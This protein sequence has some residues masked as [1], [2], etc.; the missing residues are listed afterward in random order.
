MKIFNNPKSSYFYILKRNAMKKILATLFLAVLMYPVVATSVVTVSGTLTDMQSGNPIP[1]HLVTIQ[2]DSSQGFIYYKNVY[3]DNNGVYMDTIFS[4][5]N[6]GTIFVQTWDC[7]NDLHQAS[8]SYGPGNY[9][10]VQDFSICNTPPPC[11]ASFSYYSTGNLGMQFIDQSTGYPATWLWDFGDGTTSD[12]QSP[13]HIFPSAGWYTVQ[14]TIADSSAG[15]T[16]TYSEP[17]YVS[18]STGTGCVAAFTYGTNPADSLTISFTDLSEGNPVSWTWS[19][20]DGTYSA[21]QNPVHTYAQ[22]GLYQVCLTIQGTD[23]LCFDTSCDSIWVG[24]NTLQCEAMF[25]YYADSNGTGYGI[26]FIDLSIGDITGWLWEF[27]DG[28]GSTEQNPYHVYAD[29]GTYTVCLTIAGPDSSC[30]DTYCM[31]VRIGNGTDCSSYF[32]Y[33]AVNLTV[34]FAGYMNNSQQATYNWQFGD[35]STGQGQSVTHTYGQPGSY[36]VELTTEDSTGCLYSSWQTLIVGD[37][38]LY[39]QVYGQ[40]FEGSFPMGY[41]MVMIF[42]A[43]SMLNYLPYM[44]YSLV[45]SSGIYYFAYVPAG[46]YYIWAI[47]YGTGYLPT[48][49][50]DVLFWEDATVVTLGEPQNSYD[51]HLIP[52]PGYSTGPGDIEGHIGSGQIKSGYMDKISMLIENESGQVL[53]HAPVN[54]EGNFDFTGLSHG[55]YFLLAELP[56]CPSDLVR[57]DITPENEHAVVNLTFSNGKILGVDEPVSLAGSVVLYPNPARDQVTVALTL[58]QPVTA[59]V[60]LVGMTGQVVYHERVALVRGG[61]RIVLSLAPVAPG[62]YTVRIV[63]GEGVHILQKLLKTP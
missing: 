35:G 33:S 46:S 40:V 55:T 29:T 11:E 36:T 10:L 19:F 32:L 14:L 41:G 54:A 6:S 26:H 12:Q 34:T 49:Y 62:I 3:T 61:N 51:I 31:A 20:G 60:E 16:D 38:T 45:D 53:S 63:A 48:F 17:V 24:S 44:D 47:P 8:L 4:S 39:Y 56:G 37:T 23:S 59:T 28:A 18:D 52:A 42:S 9:D 25:T 27:G 58:E 2:S 30:Y 1:Q 15:C 57:V 21:E 13:F 7:N 43:D 50:G 22:A 5:L